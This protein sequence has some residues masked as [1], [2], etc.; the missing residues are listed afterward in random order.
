MVHNWLAQGSGCDQV[1]GG[2][3]KGGKIN[4]LEIAGRE[5]LEECPGRSAACELALD[6]VF[7]LYHDMIL[8]LECRKSIMPIFFNEVGLLV[9]IHLGK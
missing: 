7:E 8:I 9:W 1:L 5:R 3:R 4:V 2:L 6:E